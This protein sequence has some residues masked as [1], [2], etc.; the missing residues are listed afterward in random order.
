MQVATVVRNGKV[1]HPSGVVEGG[2]LG[3][4][5]GKIVAQG[6]GECPLEA[7]RTIDAGGHYVIPGFV[8][9]HVHMD[10]PTHSFEDGCRYTSNAVASGVTSVLHFMLEHEGLVQG[11]EKRS[12]VFEQN[13]FIDGSFHA[14]I[15][16]MDQVK[17][18]PKAA[19]A[20]VTSFK[21]F[22]PYRGAE[23]VP[24]LV[25]VDDGIVFMGMREIGQLSPKAIAM[26]HCENIELFFKLK[27]E[28]RITMRPN[29]CTGSST[30]PRR[31]TPRAMWSI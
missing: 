20:G 16:S 3:I 17:E 29:P 18:I 11:I 7:G 4:D 24:P 5:Q 14:G 6:S 9:S 28:C 21:F 13:S 31:P 19:E 27:E 15:F 10:W 1:V 12:A 26:F 22:V 30:S 2:W 25:G 8:D 23:A